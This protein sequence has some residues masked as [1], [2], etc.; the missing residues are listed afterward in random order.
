MRALI[1]RVKLGQVTIDCR[2]HGKISSGLVILLG[3]THA[4]SADDV[5]YLVNKCLN[6]RIFGDEDKRMNQSLL[7][8]QGEVLIVSQ[9][10]LYGNAAK[11]RRPSFTDAA[12]PQHA[13]ELYERFVAAVKAA[14]ISVATGKFGAEM[15]VSIVN[16]GPVTMM[17]ESPPQ[18]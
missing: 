16:D 18:S 1:Q 12:E 3:I 8:I 10:T 9:F 15:V 14:G 5:D 11:G 6:L 7:D 4:D 2:I 13:L 17:L